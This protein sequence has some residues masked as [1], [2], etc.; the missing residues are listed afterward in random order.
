MKNS[1]SPFR[2]LLCIIFFNTFFLISIRFAEAS[3]KP[4][5]NPDNLQNSDNVIVSAD[6]GRIDH[7]T[8]NIDLF[9]NIKLLTR[10][11]FA[12][13]DAMK[14][15]KVK[16]SHGVNKKEDTT[17]ELLGNVRLSPVFGNFSGP[18]FNGLLEE[19]GLVLLWGNK[20]QF[21]FNREEL[22]VYGDVRIK[23]NL[24]N[25]KESYSIKCYEA[26]NILY[27]VKGDFFLI[28]AKKD[29]IMLIDLDLE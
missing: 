4:S 10:D 24:G 15:N 13:A 11:I 29:D 3:S 18:S 25:S 6:R 2:L 22:K 27:D 16:F 21:S 23:A 19:R 26:D 12:S 8:G 1:F 14:L 28:E 9:S 20:A 7:V 5:F 17:I